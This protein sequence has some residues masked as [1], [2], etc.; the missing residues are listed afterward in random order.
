M[1]TPL[2]ARDGIGPSAVWLP[3][4]P[5]RT[6]LDFLVERFHAIDAPTWM[7]RM[8][9]GE[10]VDA[11][12]NRLAPDSPYRSRVR[13]YYYR[14]IEG[15]PVV[16]FEEHV[17]HRDAHLLVVDK[18]HFL[19]VM[20]AGRFLAESLLVRLKRRLKLDCLAPIHRLDR[21]TAGLVLFSIRPESRRAYHALFE[22]REVRKTYHALAAW[23]PDLAFP[24]MR[25]SRLVEGEPFFLMRETEGPP[26]AET[27][28]EVL[29][30]RGARALYRLT[31]VTG[32]KHQLRVHMAAL[33]MPIEGDPLYPRRAA[34]AQDDYARP[35]RLLAKELE[36]TDP[37][38][39]T[40][41]CFVSPRTLPAR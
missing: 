13:L 6:V 4:G 15:E 23:R 21:D 12:G 29:A 27:R 38:T 19:P 35:L 28:V 37:L 41:R 22:R 14:E 11:D 39:G 32:R 16:P 2:P 10:V 34:V 5:W 33:G 24:I 3:P 20:P 30:V 25:R 26:N 7:A 40:R 8:A 31:P 36:F 17:L 9:K 1:T 18:P